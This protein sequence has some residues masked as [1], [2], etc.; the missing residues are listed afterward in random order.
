[1]ITT[2]VQDAN[3]SRIAAIQAQL[4]LLYVSPDSDCIDPDLVPSRP[5]RPD[6]WIALGLGELHFDHGPILKL[7]EP[8]QASFLRSICSAAATRLANRATDADMSVSF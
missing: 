2:N 6:N 8:R 4:D 3:P 1:M 7:H 5:G